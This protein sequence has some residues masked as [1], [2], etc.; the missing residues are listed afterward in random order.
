VKS[1]Y[2]Y[3]L[4][5]DYPAGS[6]RPGWTPARW[7]EY[8]AGIA[9]KRERARVR[10]HGFRWPREHLYLS[11]GGAHS[12]ALL[13]QY[14]GARVDVQRSE[15]VTWWEDGGDVMDWWPEPAGLDGV[16][17]DQILVVMDEAARFSAA[18]LEEAGR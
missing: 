9:D 15:P 18:S 3:R 11:A 13:L 4:V 10:R 2:V 14:F 17:P 8:L 16:S 7:E 12:R 5:I 6:D 1:V